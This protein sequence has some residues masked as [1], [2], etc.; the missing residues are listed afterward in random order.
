MIAGTLPLDHSFLPD[1]DQSER[2]KHRRERHFHLVEIP[3]L[4]LVGFAILMILVLL[5]HAVVRDVGDA[6]P[7]LLGT[8]VLIYSAASWAVLYLLFDRVRPPSLGTA[9][10]CA[11]VFV[12]VVAI[13]LT[14]ADRSWL[15]FR[16]SSAPPTRRTPTSAAC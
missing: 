11:D 1:I 2:Q 7:Y 9:F 6:H 13:Y 12:F 4:R 8:I 3:T 16:S 5:R 14:G 15:F 10:L